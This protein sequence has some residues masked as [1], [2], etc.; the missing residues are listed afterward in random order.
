M[1]HKI[2]CLN[3]ELL[4][5]VICLIWLAD[6]LF[7]KALSVNVWLSDLTAHKTAWLSKTEKTKKNS[8]AC[9]V[10]SHPC[11][12]LNQQGWKSNDV[13]W[14]LLIQKYN[15]LLAGS[16]WIILG[17][18]DVCPV[19]ECWTPGNPVANQLPHWL[20]CCQQDCRDGA[21]VSTSD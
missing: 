7:M 12:F 5:A 11:L 21:V 20:L 10:K 18:S 4:F 6:G 17:W 19:P 14:D 15:L 13:A 8:R 1:S 16:L 2:F 9:A 3:L